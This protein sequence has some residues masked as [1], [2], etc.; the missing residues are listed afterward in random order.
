MSYFKPSKDELLLQAKKDGVVVKEELEYYKCVRG[1]RLNNVVAWFYMIAFVGLLVGS[2]FY[3]SDL[4]ESSD[5]V[6]GVVPCEMEF[7]CF[8]WEND[9]NCTFS[10]EGAELVVSDGGRICKR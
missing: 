4:L 3:I 10:T 1:N 6:S 9:N 7:S 2:A 5:A 8:N